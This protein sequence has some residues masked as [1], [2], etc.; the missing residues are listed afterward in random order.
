[1]FLTAYHFDGDPDALV[2]GHQRMTASFP[3]EVLDLH[4]C[5]TTAT[6]ITVYD[7]C[8]SREIAAAFGR[9]PEFTGA[10]AAAGLPAPHIEPIGDL[11]FV[12]VRDTVSR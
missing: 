12:A 7:A 5:V 6:G 3:P 9:S 8:P 1:M 10:V 4:L 11:Q 2:A